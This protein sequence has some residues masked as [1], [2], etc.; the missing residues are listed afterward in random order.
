MP[1]PSKEEDSVLMLALPSK[2]VPRASP[3]PA[4]KNFTG[5]LAMMVVSQMTA[6]GLVG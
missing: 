4:I 5:A 6:S 2:Y 3:I 1:V